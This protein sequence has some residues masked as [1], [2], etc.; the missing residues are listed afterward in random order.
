MYTKRQI[1]MLTEG[2]YFAPRSRSLD[3][4]GQPVLVSFQRR[5]SPLGHCLANPDEVPEGIRATRL[6]DL[7]RFLDPRLADRPDA[8]LRFMV[9][10]ALDWQLLS[11]YRGHELGF[12]MDLEAWHAK[13]AHFTDLGLSGEGRKQIQV[14]LRRWAAVAGELDGPECGWQLPRSEREAF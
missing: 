4:R 9:V 13:D 2:R 5:K 11:C 1:I 14:L 7:A 3:E 10:E 12:W 8:R 6:P